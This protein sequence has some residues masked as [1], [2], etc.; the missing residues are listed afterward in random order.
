VFYVGGRDKSSLTRICEEHHALIDF[1]MDFT[2]FI[3]RFYLLV[4]N[5]IKK[6]AQLSEHMSV[7]CLLSKL[8][9]EFTVINYRSLKK[10]ISKGRG[11]FGDNSFFG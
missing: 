4:G 7:L 3:R 10:T 2:K 9:F 8:V 6:F 11:C 5:R 1:E